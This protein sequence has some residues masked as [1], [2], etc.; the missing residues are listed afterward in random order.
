MHNVELYEGL[1]QVE[2]DKATRIQLYY[3]SYESIKMY[4]SAVIF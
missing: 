4:F 2:L 1:G 3:M